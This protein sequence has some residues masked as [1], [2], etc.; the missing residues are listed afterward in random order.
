MTLT[1]LEK[2]ARK[3]QTEFTAAAYQFALPFHG[4]VGWNLVYYTNA[5]VENKAGV[6]IVVAALLAKF[7]KGLSTHFLWK[8][9]GMG[10]IPGKRKKKR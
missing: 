1:F 10:N 6:W 3:E 8:H 5:G 9:V 7:G 4:P 2:L